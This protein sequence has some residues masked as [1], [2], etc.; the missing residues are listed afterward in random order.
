MSLPTDDTCEAMFEPVVLSCQ[1]AEPP[2]NDRAGTLHYNTRRWRVLA[3]V[4]CDDDLL[5][6]RFL[7]FEFNLLL[8]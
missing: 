7:L 5:F 3:K 2:G 8:E 1:V 4:N 6:D